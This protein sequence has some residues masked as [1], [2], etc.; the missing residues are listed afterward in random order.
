MSKK[1]IDCI[2][3]VRLDSTR[4]PGKALADI[5]GKPLVSHI[6]ERLKK[7]KYIRNIII[8]TTED[9]FHP[10]KN[11]LS[12]YQ[13]LNYFIGDK[14]NVLKR[15]YNA[16]EKY[17]SEIIIRATGDNPLVDP[18][19]LDR[20]V[21]MTI[22][23]NADLLH[24]IGIPLGTGVEVIKRKAM[25]SAYENAAT[26][27]EKEHVTPYIYGHRDKFIVLEPMTSEFYYVPDLR[28]T[29]DTEDD[30]DNV[31]EIFEF[32]KEKSFISMEDIINFFQYKELMLDAS[33]IDFVTNAFFY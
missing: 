11:A 29:I 14:D 10:L 20:A 30:L 13:Y 16:S 2:L 12:G 19:Y 4:L 28:V 23:T 27:Y 26:Q 7:S 22:D 21:E 24:Y 3:Q 6:I 18:E 5:C 8:A 17:D 33:P 1:A 25:E 9:S 32:Y 31:R 15:Y